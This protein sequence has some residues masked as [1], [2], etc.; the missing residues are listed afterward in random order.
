MSKLVFVLNPE[1][2]LYE[3]NK[4]AFCSSR[5]I[6]ETFKRKHKHVMRTIEWLRPQVDSVLSFPSLNLSK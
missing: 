6:A 5:Q 3:R 4:Q 1:F 2:S